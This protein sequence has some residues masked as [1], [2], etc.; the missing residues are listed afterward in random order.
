MN[1]ESV[2]ASIQETIGHRRL[3]WVGTRGT[4][5][6]PLL[7]IEQFEGV[8]GLIAPLGVP[9]WPDGAEDY[10]ESISGVRVDLNSYSV[11][12]DTSEH[13]RELG[14]RL[15]RAMTPGTLVAAYRPT[16]FLASAYFPRME[17]ATYLGMFHGHQAAYDH[18][19]WVETELASR[20]VPTIPWHYFSDSDRT[21]MHEWMEGRTCVMRANYSDGGAGLMVFD[22]ANGR[23]SEPAHDGGFLA[24]APLLEPNVPLNVSG[25]V[26]PDGTVTAK[27][28]S[29]QLIGIDACTGRR[30]GYCGND[31]ASVHAALGDAGLA[32]LEVVTRNTGAWL[33]SRGYTGAFG[34][35]ALLYGGRICLTEVNPRFQGSSAAAASVL[36]DAGACDLYL[37]HLCAVLGMEAPQEEMT[38]AEQ[39]A[40]QAEKG[41]ALTQVV[42]YN[43]GTP[44]T[45]R[46]CVIVPD[47]DYGDIKGTPDQGIVVLPEA[48]LF[49]MFVNETLTTTGFDLPAWLTTDIARLTGELYEATDAPATVEEDPR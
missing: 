1:R 38:L 7:A 27:S 48:M 35:D 25:C 4:D 21:V 32:E 16:A 45:M 39:G 37:D 6:H 8:V 22:K 14:D 44:R 34:L 49:K 9:S 3:M 28:P 5:A 15:R 20:G 33:H 47:V 40:L 17:H 29:L 10:L 43:T 19:P 24:V 23:S 26:F 2:I 18:K 11:D 36:A 12:A 30:F 42:C 13:R 31:F 46:P 41:R